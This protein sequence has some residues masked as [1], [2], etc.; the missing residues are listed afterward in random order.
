MIKAPNTMPRLLGLSAIALGLAMSPIAS[1]S[2]EAKTVGGAEMSAQKNIVENASKSNDHETLVKAVKAAGLVDTLSGKGPF[3]V[4]APTD[5][6]FDKLPKGTLASLLKPENKD[7]LAK[8][9]TYHVVPTEAM[10]AAG[11][12][13]SAEATILDWSTE[14]GGEMVVLREGTNRWTCF[15]AMPYYP[16]GVG[17]PMCV[18]EIWLALMKARMAGEEFPPVT[19]PGIAYM[20]DGG[21]GPSISDPFALEPAP[22]G[23]WIKD[24]PPHIMILT[25]GDLST[26]TQV[27]G[28]EPWAMF[29]DTSFAHLMVNIHMPVD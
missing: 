26:F 12:A 3:T 24:A 18:D 5:A 11:P 14:P 2:V 28:N 25:P 1:S 19:E 9:L 29:P 21:G 16:E 15:P 7:Q 10:S 20:L 17:R 4:F 6:A 27:P 23:D 22:G 8:I 13:I